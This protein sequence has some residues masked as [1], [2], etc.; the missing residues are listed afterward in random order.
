MAKKFSCTVFVGENCEWVFADKGEMSQETLDY[1]LEDKDT[2]DIFV[3][4]EH[5]IRLEKG[6]YQA[7]CCIWPVSSYEGE[8]DYDEIFVRLGNRI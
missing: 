5:N 1:V 4:V 3:G 8:D 2:I 6:L 7:T